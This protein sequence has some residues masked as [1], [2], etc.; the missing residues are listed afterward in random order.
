MNATASTKWQRISNEPCNSLP[1][2]DKWWYPFAEL[3]DVSVVYVDLSDSLDREA[4]AFDYLSMI[5]RQRAQRFYSNVARRNFLLCRA[6]LRVNLCNL[7]GCR[8]SDLSISCE[9]NQKPEASVQEL[10]VTIEFNVSHTAGHGLL[11]FANNGRLGVD[12]E[13]RGVRHDIDGEIRKVFSPLEQALLRSSEP[14]EK[15]ELF[16]RLWTI[17]ESV[18][19]ATGE[20]F[21]ADTTAFTVPLP[22]IQG[23]RQSKVRFENDPAVRWNI[24]NLENE[25]FAAAVAHEIY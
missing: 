25:T 3:D 1:I 8:N 17:K 18:I 4:A 10:P 19:K 14:Q 7:V 9:R 13:H 11:A 22:L 15:E 12:I 16:L 20:G 24:F 23:G 21:R 5:E 2:N 6:A